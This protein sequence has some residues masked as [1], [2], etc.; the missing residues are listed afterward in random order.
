MD[1]LTVSNGTV[2]ITKAD[3]T[4]TL[5]DIVMNYGESINVTVITTGAIGITAEIDGNDVD[6]NNFTIPISGLAVGNYTLT[7]TTIADGDH[8]S[9]NK[10]VAVIVNEHAV[11]S[12]PDVTKYYKGS[13]RFVVTVTDSKN[14]PLANQSVII[15]VNGV[16]YTRTTDAN[17]TASIAISL[18]SGQYN[19]TTIVDNDTV[20]STITVLPTVNL[21]IWL[22]CSGMEHSSMQHLKT[23]KEITWL[24]E[25]L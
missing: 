16:N 4:I 5:D 7:V 10:T 12:A 14:N 24:K 20:Y 13:E 19:V 8:N 3:S 25:Q 21:L 6:V 17:G 23:P 1:N 15:S 2:N 22:K 11:V 9:V 18:V